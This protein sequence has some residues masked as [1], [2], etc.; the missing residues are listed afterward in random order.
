MSAETFKKKLLHGDKYCAVH[1]CM[2]QKNYGVTIRRKFGDDI[3]T[4]PESQYCPKCILD[5]IHKRADEKCKTC[6]NKM[7]VDNHGSYCEHCFGEAYGY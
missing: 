7:H 5:E 3:G 1:D 4:D 2:T 6:G